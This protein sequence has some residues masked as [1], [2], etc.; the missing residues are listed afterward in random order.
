MVLVNA[1]AAGAPRQHWRWSAPAYFVLDWNIHFAGRRLRSMDRNQKTFDM[2][3]RDLVRDQ[4]ADFPPL[5]HAGIL[6]AH[7]GAELARP[8]RRMNFGT[9]LRSPHGRS[10]ATH[11]TSP[12]WA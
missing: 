3:L 1:F 7:R 12:S 4:V 8:W 6:D 11:A 10:H 9:R 5:P 2:N